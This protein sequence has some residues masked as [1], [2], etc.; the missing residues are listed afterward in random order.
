MKTT[1]NLIRVDPV[2]PVIETILRAAHVIRSGG[3]V[4]LPTTGLYG[5]AADALQ[6]QAVDRLFRL[7]GRDSSKPILVLIASADMLSQVSGPVSALAKAMMAHFWPGRV[8][9]I[10]PARNGLPPGLTADSGKIGVRQV[11]HPVAQALVRAV[12]TPLTGTSANLSGA[13]GCAS[14]EAIDAAV[15]DAV[16]LVLDSGPLA[17]G[18]GST[19]VDMTGPI[20]IVLREGAVSAAKILD[21]FNLLNRA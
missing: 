2:Q 15:I 18:V 16:D 1:A 21:V 20:P 6:P 9:F 14:I 5:L 12:G 3:V 11:A 10:V 8:T 4:V 7:K 13:G 19:V 17:G